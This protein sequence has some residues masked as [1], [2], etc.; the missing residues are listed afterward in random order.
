PAELGVARRVERSMELADLGQEEVARDEHGGER[1]DRA[2]THARER[3]E[4]DVLGT[5]RVRRVV[6]YLVEHAAVVAER[7]PRPR[8]EGE[9]LDQWEGC[10]HRRFAERG[11]CGIDRALRTD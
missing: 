6:A 3:L 4:L 10:C 5:D 1:Q 8:G 11:Q 9:R 2:Q 7:A